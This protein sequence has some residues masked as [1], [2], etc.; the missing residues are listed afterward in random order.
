MRVIAIVENH[1][2]LADLQRFA[3]ENSVPLARVSMA[4]GAV[5]RFAGAKARDDEVYASL[6][7][8]AEMGKRVARAISDL[9]LLMVPPEAAAAAPGDGAGKDAAA[10]AAA[11]SSRRR[12]KQPSAGA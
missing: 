12:T 7:K 4:Y 6:F 1:I 3:E 11:P 5:L 8:S 10:V 9:L 2:T